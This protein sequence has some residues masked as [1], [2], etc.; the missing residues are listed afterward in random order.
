MAVYQQRG[1]LS[2]SDAYT[3]PNS[4]CPSEDRNL[5]AKCKLAK[6]S[7]VHSLMS[8]PGRDESPSLRAIASD[9][10]SPTYLPVRDIHENNAG[11]TQS[12]HV[13]KRVSDSN[14]ILNKLNLY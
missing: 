2:D 8:S 6:E 3:I 10:A 12:L 1:H 13:H 11:F 9:A 4:C 5:R 7:Y 14:R